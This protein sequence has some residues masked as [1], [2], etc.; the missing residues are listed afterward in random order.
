[1]SGDGGGSGGEGHDRF[2]GAE[3][4]GEI[5]RQNS[6]EKVEEETELARGFADGTGD[7]GGADISGT[8]LSDVDAVKFAEQKAEWDGSD[9]IGCHR[10]REMPCVHKKPVF[11]T[12]L[13]YTINRYIG[14]C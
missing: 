5:D 14:R 7:V 12:V 6:L 13:C 2:P 4:S 3:E 9:E 11:F 8:D 10:N 1:M